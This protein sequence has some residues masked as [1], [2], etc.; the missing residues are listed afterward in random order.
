[1][2][3][4]EEEWKEEWTSV[5]HLASP[6]P[7]S[8]GS[9]KRKS[10]CEAANLR[11]LS[12]EWEEL[13]IYQSLEEIHV[14]ALAHILRRPIIIV[15]DTVLKD[16]QGDPLAPIPFG[17]IYLPL[18]CSPQQCHHSPLVLTYDAAHFSALVVMEG[19]KNSP[20]VIPLTDSQHE[21]LSIHFLV[22]P[23]EEWVWTTEE[24]SKFTLTFS[25][26]IGLLNEYLEVEKVSIPWEVYGEDELSDKDSPD[27]G[28][29]QR[30]NS[31]SSGSPQIKPD[32]INSVPY[33]IEAPDIG[34]PLR[35]SKQWQTVAKQFGSIGK[36]VSK[37][38]KRNLSYLAGMGK[39]KKDLRRLSPVRQTTRTPMIQISRK[40]D[41]IL[42]AILN[43][44]KRLEYHEKMIN[45]YLDSAKKR[46]GTDKELKKRQAIERERL[47]QEK[48]CET[49]VVEGHRQCVNPGCV[50]YGTALTSYMCTDCFVLQKE[51]EQNR[52][53]SPYPT[54]PRYGTGKSVFYTEADYNILESVN[55]LPC[56]NVPSRKTDQTL[57]LSNSTFYNDT[58]PRGYNLTK[59]NNNA[60]A[61]P[62]PQVCKQKKPPL[63]AVNSVNRLNTNLNNAVP[64]VSVNDENKILPTKP[65]VLYNSEPSSDTAPHCYL[66]PTPCRNTRCKYF[67]N[68][69][70]DFYCSKC[71]KEYLLL[72]QIRNTRI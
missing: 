1:M 44:E 56:Y 32:L 6:E 10:T 13:N 16:V 72:N 19:D 31:D 27:S 40:Q 48:L 54:G 7:R 57:Y 58:T 20:A 63:Q 61:T 25:D 71:Y 18:E 67:G 53:T 23:G 47:Q 22:D 33:Q 8:Q 37:K 55:K 70:M 59:I 41:Y 50:L 34:D 60:A 39:P 43:T 26:Q 11:G 29:S 65:N 62:Q 66:E 14:L 3:L 24:I 9:L 42:C 21:L 12:G 28:G 69:K 45:N 49:V 36:S 15:A 52:T 64:Y 5:L 17:G 46:F 51:Q 38:L 30:S 68:C 2:V 4:T 35:N